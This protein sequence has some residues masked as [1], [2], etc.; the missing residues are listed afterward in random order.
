MATKTKTKEHSH[1]VPLR[2]K[3]PWSLYSKNGGD[4]GGYGWRRNI[5][6]ACHVISITLLENNT[7]WKKIFHFFL[8]NKD[9]F[10]EGQ[11]L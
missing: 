10:S 8:K 4:V 5:I 6:T 1:T 11:V 9:N 2:G 7:E 3:K